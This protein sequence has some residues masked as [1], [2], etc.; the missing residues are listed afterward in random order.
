M[1]PNA[2][3]MPVTFGTHLQFARGQRIFNFGDPGTEMY[4]I[5]SG[6]VKIFMPSGQFDLIL[7]KLNKGDFFGEMA[8][9]E[10]LPRTAGAE[11]LEDSELIALSQKDFKFLIQQH[12]EIAMKVLGKLSAR[13]RDADHLI[14]L[15]LL[16][17]STSRVIH[18]LVK[19]ALKQFGSKE[20]LPREWFLP[21]S[22]QDLARESGVSEAEI[23]R[24]LDELERLKLTTRGKDGIII[25]QHKKMKHYLEYLELK[26]RE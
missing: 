17:D 2:N 4:V 6:Q 22:R 15:L 14:E 23:D 25:K 24:V 8:L 3:P 5:L 20:K 12:P 13:L 19:M 7:T 21:V 1:T 11:A 10:D 26:G 16:G 9:L 18:V